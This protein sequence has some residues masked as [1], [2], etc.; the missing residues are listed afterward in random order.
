M[1]QPSG[2]LSGDAGPVAARGVLLREHDGVAG[3]VRHGLRNTDG[4]RIAGAGVKEQV[5]GR[6]VSRSVA[7]RGRARVV[8]TAIDL[9]HGA[10]VV[11]LVG[12]LLLDVRKEIVE[13]RADDFPG[14]RVAARDI[15]VRV[16]PLVGGQQDLVQV[17]GALDPAG[18][19]PGLLHRGERQAQQHPQDGDDHQQLD[20]RECPC[21]QAGA[22]D[23]RHPSVREKC[24]GP[25]AFARQRAVRLRGPV[26]AA[27][28]GSDSS[29]TD[30]IR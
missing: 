5:V 21:G 16:V 2:T 19:G 4:R 13:R 25:A 9:D 30:I 24:A 3:A 20:E 17:V 29:V 28:N 27:K 11:G 1:W 26:A 18:G 12:C 10:V 22:R 15:P 8:G 6:I 23:M 14:M 7:A